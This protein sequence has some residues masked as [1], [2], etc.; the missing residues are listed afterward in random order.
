MRRGE[1]NL[2]KPYLLKTKAFELI[3]EKYYKSSDYL[4]PKH[5][6]NLL[7]ICLWG[8]RPEYVIGPK[9]IIWGKKR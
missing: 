6:R 7:I 8:F 2:R 1:P 5:I 4:I 9:V 3:L